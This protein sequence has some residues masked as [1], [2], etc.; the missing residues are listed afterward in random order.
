MSQQWTQPEIDEQFYYAKHIAKALFDRFA[1]NKRDRETGIDIQ[2]LVDDLA[3]IVGYLPSSAW[4]QVY[5][6]RPQVIVTT[7]ESK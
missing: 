3:A 2:Y 4:N 6:V 5:P 7:T 1:S